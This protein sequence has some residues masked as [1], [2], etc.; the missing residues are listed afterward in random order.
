M[1]AK[2]P[3][4]KFRFE[5]ERINLYHLDEDILKALEEEI[6]TFLVGTR[7]TGKTTLLNALSWRER[8]YNNNLKQALKK[9]IF[10]KNYIGIYLK[11][12]ESQTGLIH[13]WLSPTNIDL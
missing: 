5:H 4:T 1:K 9:K 8:L 3:F 6:P 7:G 10:D 13:N 12:S 2:S 11:L